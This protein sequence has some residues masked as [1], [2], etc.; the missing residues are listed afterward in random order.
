MIRVD[1]AQADMMN[2][3]RGDWIFVIV[4]LIAYQAY[5]TVLVIKSDDY[6]DEVKLKMVVAVWLVPVAGAV[7]VRYAVHAARQR[8][9]R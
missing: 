3:T 6:D 5:V 4:V 8:R 1:E 7:L 2:M 9:Q